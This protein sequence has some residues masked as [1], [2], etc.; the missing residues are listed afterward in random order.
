MYLA[1]ILLMS[2]LVNPQ[3]MLGIISTKNV[4]KVPFTNFDTKIITEVM[5]FELEFLFYDTLFLKLF[6]QNTIRKKFPS[7]SGPL[8]II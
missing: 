5:I 6:L 1:S 7:G 2:E 8:D 3:Q 4:H